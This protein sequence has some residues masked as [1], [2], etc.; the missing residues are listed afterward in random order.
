MPKPENLGKHIL[1]NIVKIDVPIKTKGTDHI[2]EK[3]NI[4]ASMEGK[5]ASLIITVVPEPSITGLFR[6]I[7]LSAKN[8]K[9]ISNFDEYEGILEIYYKHPLIK[10]YMK[11][12]FRNRPDFLVF[13]ADTFT[14]EAMKVVVLSGIQEN[15]SRFPLF[16]LDHPEK[17]IE[18]HITREYYEQGPKMHELFLKLVKK[19]RLGEE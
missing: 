16:D 18:D 13:V 17:E 14:R 5:E 8:T 10:K 3:A 19:I 2:G 1:K 6:N 12:S 4:M 11:K 15:S 7:R 9:R